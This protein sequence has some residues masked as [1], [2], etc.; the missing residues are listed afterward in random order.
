MRSLLAALFVLITTQSAQTQCIQFP[1][2]VGP[3]EACA[4]GVFPDSPILVRL[5]DSI[6]LPELR[7][8]NETDRDM[9][10]TIEWSRLSAPTF[11]PIVIEQVTL[12]PRTEMNLP[13]AA[14]ETRDLLQIGS[15][16]V[17]IGWFVVGGDYE[18]TVERSN[19]EVVG[20]PTG[21]LADLVQ[22]PVRLCALENSPLAGGVEPGGLVGGQPLVEWLQEATAAWLAQA[23]ILF[24]P[25]FAPNGI[26]VIQDTETFLTG[27]EQVGD[28]DVATTFE[29][30]AT[31]LECEA[32]WASHYPSQR[33][34]IAN[35]ARNLVMN[36]GDAVALAVAAGPPLALRVQQDS[37]LTGRRGDDLCGHPR[38]LTVDDVTSQFAVVIDP[39]SFREG[40]R[41]VVLAHELGHTLLL[42]HGNGLDDNGDG[43]ES[44]LDGRRR[45]D[46]HCDPQGSVDTGSGRGR[47]VE[48]VN[49]GAQNDGLMRPS[50]S[51]DTLLRPLQIEQGR[52]VAKLYP[53]AIFE[54]GVVQAG[55]IVRSQPLC[56]T[57]APCGLSNA[58]SI[59]RSQVAIAPPNGVASISQTLFGPLLPNADARYLSFLDLDENSNT[60]CDPADLGLP[61]RLTGL[62]LIGELQLS[63]GPNLPITTGKLWSC[64]A[65]S[66]QS[67][68][69]AEV[70]V[71]DQSESELGGSLFAILSLRIDPALLQGSRSMR[72]Q[73]VAEGARGLVDRLP[74]RDPAVGATIDLAP[75]ALPQCEVA[76]LIVPPGGAIGLSTGG[77][78]P[79]VDVVVL[80][81]GE[82]VARGTTD[83]N[84]DV[85]LD[86]F[87]PA[88]SDSGPAAITL[89]SAAGSASAVCT[90]IVAGSP[91]TPATTAN[92]SPAPSRAGWNN[93]DV[94]VNL[95]ALAGNRGVGEIRYGA[96]GAEPIPPTSVSGDTA[97]VALST[98]GTTSLSYGAV[99]SGGVAET[100]RRLKIKIDTVA[101]TISGIATP[102]ANAFGWNNS[103]VTVRFHCGDS[104]SGLWFCTPPT[105]FGS[106]GANQS[107]LGEAQDLATNSASVTVGG[108]SIDQTSPVVAYS[109]NNGTYGL[110]D[111]VE[112]R[113]DASDA[114]SGVATSSCQ[115]VAGS[116]YTFSPDENRFHAE[117]IDRAGNRSV[118]TTRFEVL[119]T[120]DDLCQLGE[121]FLSK[122]Q[123][124]PWIASL[125]G[126][127]LCRKLA[128]AKW[129]QLQ[130]RDRWAARGIES[131]VFLAWV[132]SYLTHEQR[133]YL[134]A[135][136]QHL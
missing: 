77:F 24:R 46:V 94:R 39:A 25:A 37:P 21:D 47:P 20:L 64:Q 50:I 63:P 62:E 44:P 57:K 49:A 99:D 123:G 23:H 104:L 42:D 8:V 118:A 3:E 120:H 5:G 7:F 108:V 111:D 102:S 132:A 58:L 38:D 106:E 93:E 16:Q 90:L 83:A 98:D 87:M 66:W 32:A 12:P 71:Y 33:G 51:S 1:V 100:P 96:I 35:S 134:I 82:E 121:R 75:P 116:A 43:L 110:L 92:L 109:G 81:G 26:P 69:G 76:S 129:Q 52:E 59:V 88:N 124:K 86:F 84:G 9:D 36:G 125:L 136:A 54:D 19:I 74:K 60:G 135:W 126:K 79:N 53:G 13:D 127:A 31:A 68:P 95:V 117:A 101:P 78:T 85:S 40:D 103:E 28:I 55:T 67:E 18:A 14:I 2:G 89:L 56:G 130:G 133:S 80:A 41:N 128:W 61:T 30:K 119:P 114:L 27:I 107:V 91:V 34:L 17:A 15:A 70:A 115:D 72:M 22:V 73:T 65:G 105:I 112:I 45:F 97:S 29:A 11:G 113:C 6:P 10:F 122:P 131:F 48:D 4:F